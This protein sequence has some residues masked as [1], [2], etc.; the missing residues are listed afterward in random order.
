ML[1][2][3]QIA[4]NINCTTISGEA[5]NL[6]E[7][8]GKRIL[9]KF[10][11]FSGCPVAQRQVKELIAQQNELNTAGIE[12][13]VLLH[14]SKENIIPVYK[15]VPGLHIIA[16][17]QK[18]FYRL[19]NS[20]FSWIGTFSIASWIEIFKSFFK[21]YFPL[22]NRFATTINA[23]PSDFLI[24]ANGQIAALHYGKNAGDSWTAAEVLAKAEHLND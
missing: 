14:S 9:V 8:K 24:D 22:F 23:I 3:N 4:P 18:K 20:G 5:I 16:D 15:E 11:R 7:L 17:N 2:K 13:I 6:S 19:Y 12:T 1:T 10:H 21:G